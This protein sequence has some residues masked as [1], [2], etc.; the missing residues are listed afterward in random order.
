[1]HCTYLY[2]RNDQWSL[3]SCAKICKNSSTRWK[4]KHKN[5]TNTLAHNLGWDSHQQ[6]L[7]TWD[8]RI[9]PLES[10]HLDGIPQSR[11]G[12]MRFKAS[13]PQVTVPPLPLSKN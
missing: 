1:M 12:A 2:H 4:Y 10:T 11:P 6:W 3:S 7:C 9:D 5:V 13:E 8:L